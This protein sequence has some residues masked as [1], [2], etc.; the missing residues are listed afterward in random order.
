MARERSY[1][2]PAATEGDRNGLAQPVQSV[3]RAIAL[4]KAVAHGPQPAS[5]SEL[6]AQV[7]LNRS[8][9]WRLLA[10]LERH[11]LVERDPVSQRFDIGYATIRLADSA[12]HDALVR[13]ARPIMETLA[14]ETSE[15]VTL[16]VATS[17]SLLYV[18]QVDPPGIMTPSWL[19]RPIPLHATS[20]G[21]VFLAW[22]PEVERAAVLPPQ[23]ERFT[24]M[25]ITDGADL[26]EQLAEIR[27]SGYGLCIGE[28]EE[29]SNGVS[30]A[31]QDHRA[32]PIAIVNVWGPSQRL[33]ERRL[34]ELGRFALTAAHKIAA[35]LDR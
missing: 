14:V 6:A 10:T 2:A 31:V 7:G 9:A 30:A 15:T 35:T 8:T 28:Y 19:G 16:A 26:D 29:F 33:T 25:T 32:R 11:G 22:L 23:L 20:A 34:A 3:E 5:V 24:P 1:R 13:R 17:L 4:L 12:D 18:D 21:K 27:R